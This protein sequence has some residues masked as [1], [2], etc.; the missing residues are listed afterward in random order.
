MY[1]GYRLQL[2]SGSKLL[3]LVIAAVRLKFYFILFLISD[4]P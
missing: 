1:Y 4:A 2:L 3:G